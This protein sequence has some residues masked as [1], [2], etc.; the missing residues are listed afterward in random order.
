MLTIDMP[1]I[2]RHIYVMDVEHYNEEFFIMTT[3]TMGIM[4]VFFF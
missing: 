4:G 3:I 1:E 2:K